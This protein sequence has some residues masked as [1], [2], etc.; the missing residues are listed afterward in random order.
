MVD[1]ACISG[2]GV[3]HSLERRLR[4]VGYQ[5]PQYLQYELSSGT[6]AVES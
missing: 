1:A 4:V 2:D 5:V 3:R 6:S